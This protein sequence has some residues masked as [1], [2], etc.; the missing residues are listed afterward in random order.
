MG[1]PGIG[2]GSLDRDRFA[3]RGDVRFSLLCHWRSEGSLWLSFKSSFYIMQHQ[4]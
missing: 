4:F 1:S 2:D 3:Y